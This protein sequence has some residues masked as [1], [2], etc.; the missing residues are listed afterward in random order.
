[1]H[2][3]LESLKVLRRQNQELVHELSDVRAQLADAQERVEQ[4]RKT[5]GEAWAFARLALK[6]GRGMVAK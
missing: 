1:V 3:R 4:A 2:H 5:A 6:T